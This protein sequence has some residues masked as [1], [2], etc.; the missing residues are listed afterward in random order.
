MSDRRRIL[1][2]DDNDQTLD[3]MEVFLFRDYDI[4]TAEN[5]FAGLKQAQEQQPDL[6]MTDI[7]MPVMDGIAFF[8]EL[9]RRP[10]TSHIPVIAVTSFAEPT[11]IKSLMNVGFCGVVAKPF[12]RE[13][14]LATVAN[15]FDRPASPS[16]SATA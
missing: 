15:Q 8:N 13:Y 3:L 11:T 9:R 1:L 10:E 5:G 2:I 12:R 7:M 14:I 4:L 6:I 16:P